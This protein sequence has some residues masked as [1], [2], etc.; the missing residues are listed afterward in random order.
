MRT[1]LTLALLALATC[2]H[3]RSKVNLVSTANEKV[4]AQASTL[5]SS[6]NKILAYAGNQAEAQIMTKMLSAISH[7][8]QEGV[9]ATLEDL[10]SSKGSLKHEDL[11][12]LAESEHLSTHGN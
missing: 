4:L 2:G 10:L 12:Y 11:P 8:E 6:A 3:L 7:Q 9:A 1:F 5:S